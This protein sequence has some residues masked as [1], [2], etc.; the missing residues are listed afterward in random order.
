M[1]T[2]LIPALIVLSLSARVSNGWTTKVDY[3]LREASRNY[4]KPQGPPN[5][6]GACGALKNPVSDWAFRT[7]RVGFEPTEARTSLVFK[8]SRHPSAYN[9]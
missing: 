3:F 7:E 1:E 5:R 9:D 6:H 4:P 8:T 2:P